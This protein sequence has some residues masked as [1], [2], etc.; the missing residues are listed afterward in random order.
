M[1][2]A[3]CPYGKLRRSTAPNERKGG[4]KE[5]I[6][7]TV[8][9]YAVPVG[10]GRSLLVV[11]LFRT[12]TLVY[13]V[14]SDRAFVPQP[15]DGEDMSAEMLIG[16]QCRSHTNYEITERRAYKALVEKG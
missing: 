1:N 13:G 16:E 15:H 14:R 9:P 8:C 2:L 7:T 3:R 5:A 11:C 10:L 12:R 6:S 4:V